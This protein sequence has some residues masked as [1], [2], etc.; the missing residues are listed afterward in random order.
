MLEILDRIT[1]GNGQTDDID[2][3]HR[4]GMSI[5]KTALC[6]LGQTA[7]NPVLSAIKNFREEFEIHINEKRC[8]TLKCKDLISYSIDEERCTGCT[9]C[10]RRC[11][12]LA[13]SGLN[14]KPHF[15]HQ[16]LCIKCGDCYT[17]CKFN[18]I[19]RK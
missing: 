19:I 3:L 5:Q 2:K 6:G 18:A 4:L 17:A 12:V 8:P 11:P 7:P 13:I 15:I 16:Q 1:K 9:L 10:A 14:K